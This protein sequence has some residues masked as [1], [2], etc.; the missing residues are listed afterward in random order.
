MIISL[1]PRH[2]KS[3]TA[4]LFVEWVLGNDNRQK[5]MT[6]SYN[7]LLSTTFAKSVR[8]SILEEKADTSKIA[9]SDIFLIIKI[10]YVI[11]H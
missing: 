3:R 9:Y 10:K 1:P 8:N 7:E 4:S 6:G 11:L 5:I 2:G